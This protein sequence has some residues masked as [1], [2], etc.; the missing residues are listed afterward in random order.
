VQV[1]DDAFEQS[2]HEVEG[3]LCLELAVNGLIGWSASVPPLQSAELWESTRRVTS[4]SCRATRKELGEELFWALV[5]LVGHTEIPCRLRGVDEWKEATRGLGFDTNA[6]FSECNGSSRRHPVIELAAQFQHLDASAMAEE[7]HAPLDQW[8]LNK[9]DNRVVGILE[10]ATPEFLDYPIDAALSE[11]M[12]RL[13]RDSWQPG[14][15]RDPQLLRTMLVRMAS[16]DEAAKANGPA[17][18]RV[19]KGLGADFRML[20][21]PC[22]FALALAVS[23]I[24]LSPATLARGNVILTAGGAEGYACG[25][26]KVQG[27]RIT[28]T[29]PKV[30]SWSS[31]LVLLPL[32]QGCFLTI[33]KTSQTMKQGTGRPRIGDPGLPPVI[34][35]SEPSFLIALGQGQDE[36]RAHVQGIQNELAEIVNARFGTEEAE[37]WKQR[38]IF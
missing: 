22:L 33:F 17:L 38:L 31:V 36:V 18:A 5:R 4:I 10:G 23:G 15:A 30:P 9:V 28:L 6:R 24:G 27:K 34:V 1:V 12:L 26:E 3:P 16:H 19:G 8:L 21:E 37:K 35:S 25:C 32:M 20:W 14:L 13:W 7:I 11:S 2:P 29:L